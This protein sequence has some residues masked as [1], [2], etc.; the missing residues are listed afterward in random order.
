MYG[1]EQTKCW[2]SSTAPSS[3][4]REKTEA[5]RNRALPEG[6]AESGAE[7]GQKITS[8]ASAHYSTDLIITKILDTMPFVYAFCLVPERI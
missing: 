3:S 8:P 4:D 2:L 6:Y 1:S 5:K 7:S